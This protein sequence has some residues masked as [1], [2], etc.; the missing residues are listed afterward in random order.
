MQV[1][2]QQKTQQQQKT[3]RQQRPNRKEKD[4]AARAAARA[5]KAAK[6]AK[7]AVVV[8]VVSKPSIQLK[9]DYN[10]TKDV[11]ADRFSVRSAFA[12]INSMM[13]AQALAPKTPAAGHISFGCDEKLD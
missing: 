2:Q 4:A 9:F 12:S 5:A 8:V 11:F 1:E 10:S 6:A 3:K 13:Q 7:A